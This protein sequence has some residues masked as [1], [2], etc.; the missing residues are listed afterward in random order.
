MPDVATAHAERV[1]HPV[2]V[3]E[4][5]DGDRQLFLVVCVC[6]GKSKGSV[7]LACLLFFIKPIPSGSSRYI[8]A[9][10]HIQ[11]HRQQIV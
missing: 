7:V 5:S 6:L 2:N 4:T 10:H 1:P 11:Q 9:L 8:L 3:R